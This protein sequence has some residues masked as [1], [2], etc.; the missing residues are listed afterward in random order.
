ME[1]L[2][3]NLKVAKGSRH[4]WYVAKFTYFV[5]ITTD[6]NYVHEETQ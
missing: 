1:I 2:S 4:L 3:Y 6:K 5:L